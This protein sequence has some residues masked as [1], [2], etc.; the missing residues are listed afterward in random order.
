MAHNELIDPKILAKNMGPQSSI[1]YAVQIILNAIGEDPDR[2]GLADTPKRFAKY[3]Q[4]MTEG[5]KIDP[6]KHL[7]T[8]FDED[9]H[10]E[11]VLVKDIPFY[12]SCEHHLATIIGKC[13][14][15]YIPNGRVVGLSKLA[16]LV[17]GYAKRLQIQERMT[18]QIAD[19]IMDVLQPEGCAVLIE[20]EHLCMS[21]R[22]V[23]KPGTNTTTSAMRGNFL[24]DASLKQEFLLLIK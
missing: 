21:A 11:L 12:S 13:H 14:I 4:E 23:K 5:L 1:E 20:A 8:G 2:E 7:S 15:A 17:E 24:E 6:R 3:I 22:G 9:H 10:K 18:S 16:R 19:A